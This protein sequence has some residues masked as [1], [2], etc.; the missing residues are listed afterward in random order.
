MK[1]EYSPENIIH[2]V[3]INKKPAKMGK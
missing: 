3:L 2:L 1:E